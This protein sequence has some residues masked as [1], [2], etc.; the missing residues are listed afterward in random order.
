MTSQL[1][2]KRLAADVVLPTRATVGSAGL[3]IYALSDAICPAVGKVLLPTGLAIAVPTGCYGRIADRSSLASK[4]SIHIGG[5]VID[6]DYRGEVK[7]LLFNLS[8]KD[9]EIK[10]GDR[11]AQLIIE[12]TKT[13]NVI[14]VE[15]LDETIRNGGGFGSSGI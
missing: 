1:K 10:K 7:I 6:E 2:V 13:P 11:I 14:E 3:D 4:H 5:G 15:S 12:M 9:F 8:D